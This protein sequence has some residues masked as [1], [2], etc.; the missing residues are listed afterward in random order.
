MNRKEIAYKEATRDP[1]F[2]FQER[3]VTL[4]AEYDTY[5]EWDEEAEIYITTGK[6]KVH[7][8][9]YGLVEYGYAEITWDTTG[10]WLT[11]K[12]G[13][14]FGE[15]THYRYGSKGKNIDW[16]VYCIALERDSELAKLLNKI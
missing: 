10:V 3:R 14:D 1:I 4:K 13:E 16:R 5:V 12:E 2:L 6:K 9:D 11:R 7:L 15:R 8:N